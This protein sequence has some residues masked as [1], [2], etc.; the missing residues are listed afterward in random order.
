MD[1]DYTPFNREKDFHNGC[2]D[3][4][5]WCI[6]VISE[7]SLYFILNISPVLYLS[8]LFCQFMFD[9][10]KLKKNINIKSSNKNV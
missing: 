7:N 5:L 3:R 4:K 1:Y 6:K 9:L 2:C 8:P 10:T